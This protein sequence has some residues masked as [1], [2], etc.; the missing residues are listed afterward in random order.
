[1]G[2][3][4]YSNEIN[5]MKILIVEG[6]DF[7]GFPAGG[8][9]FFV[10]NYIKGSTD[11]VK[12]KLIGIST[13]LNEKL[14]EW[15]E[16]TIYG[17]T[18]PFMPVYF[19]NKHKLENSKPK[20]PIRIGTALGILKYRKNILKENNDIIYIHLPELIL[21]FLSP[22]RLHQNISFHLHGTVKGAVTGSRYKWIRNKL[23]A[24]IFSIYSKFLLKNTK[25]VFTVSSEGISDIKSLLK[26]YNGILK[27][28]PVMVDTN[29]FYR[30]NRKNDLRKK[31]EF[32]EKD[33]LFIY[34]G[35]LEMNKQIDLL[36]EYVA[37]LK[38]EYENLKL[39]IVGSGSDFERLK[40]LSENKKIKDRIIFM[41]NKDHDLELP[42]ILNC[43]DIFAFTSSAE[44]FPTSALEAAACG[45]PILS[46]DVGDINKIVINDETG[47]LL[48]KNDFDDFKEK[49]KNILS[50]YNYFSD[51]SIRKAKEFSN[52]KIATQIN[53]A[54]T[55]IL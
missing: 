32:N 24:N 54:F 53:K 25:S 5:I 49:F 35:R 55:E 11:E 7:M 26:K 29:V 17:K 31:Y 1:V 23:F 9:K 34:T 45:L 28:I 27:W 13:D 47:Y 33:I 15:S 21:P 8:I 50:N 18:I 12:F 30:M 22:F 42:F 2:G 52:L 43:C 16:R 3:E 14:G 39:L 4:D 41:G 37:N 19:V 46:H 51:N 10:S 40:L 48:K 36:I 6:S 20:V 44:G 38:G